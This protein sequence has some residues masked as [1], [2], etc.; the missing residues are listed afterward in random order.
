METFLVRVWVPSEPREPTPAA[1]LHGLAQHVR[2]GLTTAFADAEQLCTWLGA[3]ATE[4]GGAV[5]VTGVVAG[6]G[7]P[8]RDSDVV[9]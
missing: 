1:T 5:T 8:G 6:G 2:S 4:H 7:S 9:S 3:M